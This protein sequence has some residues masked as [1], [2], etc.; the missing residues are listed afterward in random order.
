MVL[1]NMVRTEEAGAAVRITITTTTAMATM[2]K[3]TTNRS[4]YA[5]FPPTVCLV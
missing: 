2:V 3:D 1:G 5:V 4:V